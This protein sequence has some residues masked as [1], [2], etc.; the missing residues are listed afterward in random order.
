MKF[1]EMKTE[2]EVIIANHAK[3]ELL[4]LWYVPYAFGSG[5]AAYRVKNKNLKILY[6]G[7]EFA[8]IVFIYPPHIEYPSKKE[9]EIFYDSYKELVKK[10]PEILKTNFP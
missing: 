6:D 5:F 3:F 9:I 7:K 8:M 2:F 1:L 10:L 4:E